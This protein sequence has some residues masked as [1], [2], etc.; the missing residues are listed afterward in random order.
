MFASD[1]GIQQKVLITD[2]AILDTTLVYGKLNV[3]VILRVICV[4][5]AF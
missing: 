4:L 2:V 3:L 5:F 1:I